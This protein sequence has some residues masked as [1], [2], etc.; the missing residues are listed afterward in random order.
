MQHMPITASN[1]V[2]ARAVH[3]CAPMLILAI[4]TANIRMTN[5]AKQPRQR[6]RV[7]ALHR[8]AAFL[9]LGRHASHRSTTTAP[10]IT[11]R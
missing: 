9:V 5:A 8:E 6:A 4:D 2:R 7:T 11:N 1:A 10:N 3:E